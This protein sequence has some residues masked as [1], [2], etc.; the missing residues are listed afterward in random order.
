MKYKTFAYGLIV[1]LLFTGIFLSKKEGI[2]NTENYD[3]NIAV[4][5]K[6]SANSERIHINNNWTDTKTAGICT[7]DGTESNPYTLKNLIIDA[8]GVGTAIRIENTIEHFKIENSTFFNS[9]GNF[10][11]SG[12]QLDNVSNGQLINNT[13]YDNTHGMY[14]WSSL[15]LKIVRNR[16]YNLRGLNMVFTN[17]SIFYLNTF[18]NSI[19]DIFFQWSTNQYN[20]QKMFSYTYNGSSFTN[21]LGNYWSVYTE[22]DVDG[23]GLG[24]IPFMIDPFVITNPRLRDYYPLIAPIDAYSNITIV[25]DSMDSI[26][27]FNLITL[28]GVIGII[29]ILIVITNRNNEK[30]VNKK[31]IHF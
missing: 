13:T 21:Y 25:K 24:D 18:I 30:N 4:Y 5:T 1:F 9:G 17:D 22:P 26:P 3:S 6:S 31:R 16:F 19:Y 7:G 15:N 11:D 8:G 2:K 27:G 20:S 28:L 10:H 23:D 29:T 14:I 12:I